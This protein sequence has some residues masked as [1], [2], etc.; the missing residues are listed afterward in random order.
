[1]MN[2]REIL[3]G[4]LA[5]SAAGLAPLPAFAE[6]KYPDHPIKLIVPFAAGGVVDAVKS[7]TGI[8]LSRHR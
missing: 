8:S 1:M 3:S 5:M 6:A 2:R 7:T 4:G